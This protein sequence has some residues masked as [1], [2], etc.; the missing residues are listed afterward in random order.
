MLSGARASRE[1]EYR[2]DKETQ[3]FGGKFQNSRDYLPVKE[4]N[5]LLV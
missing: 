5:A 2:G 4:L 3:K 1:I